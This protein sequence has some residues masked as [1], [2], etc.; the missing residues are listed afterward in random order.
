[1]RTTRRRAGGWLCHRRSQRVGWTSA[2]VHHPPERVGQRAAEAHRH[3]PPVGLE[4]GVAADDVGDRVGH[5]Q[6][7]EEHPRHGA[8]HPGDEAAERGEAGRVAHERVG[9]RGGDVLQEHPDAGEHHHRQAQ[10]LADGERHGVQ[11]EVVAQLVGEHAGQLVAGQLVD[12]VAGDDDEVPAAGE[13]VEVVGRAG[14]RPCSGAAG[15]GWP[16]AP[17]AR[18]CR[19][20]PAR[21]PSAGGRR[22]AAPAGAPAPGG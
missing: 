10:P 18:R 4:L 16:G 3:D 8:Q 11:P 19:A 17:S 2:G 21:R 22:R 6:A 9:G 15:G 12:R 20:W 1:M 5:Q 13:G 14:P 7:G